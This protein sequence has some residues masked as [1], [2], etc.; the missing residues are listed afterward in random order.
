VTPEECS[1]RVQRYHVTHPDQR[2]VYVGELT[3]WLSQWGFEWHDVK[4]DV[5]EAMRDLDHAP[6]LL[7]EASPITM[8][9]VGN[10]SDK[11]EIV[12]ADGG[13]EPDDSC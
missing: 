13:V 2:I 4:V 12:Y 8:A 6:Q 3:R 1:S 7:I 11:S 10:S 9:V 5:F